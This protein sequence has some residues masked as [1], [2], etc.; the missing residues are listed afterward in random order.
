MRATYYFR[1]SISV[2]HPMKKFEMTHTFIYIQGLPDGGAVGGHCPPKIFGSLT[3][4]E[5]IL[6]KADLGYSV[7][8]RQ[9]L[10]LTSI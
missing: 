3:K 1:F 8:I 9:S 4:L 6:H 7:T 2:M 10:Y 5:V